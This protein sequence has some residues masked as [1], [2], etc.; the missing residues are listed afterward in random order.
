M[1]FKL[2][3]SSDPEGL[4][5]NQH[6]DQPKDEYHNHTGPLRRGCSQ[7]ITYPQPPWPS[8][9]VGFHPDPWLPPLLLSASCGSSPKTSSSNDLRPPSPG[10]LRESLRPR[11]RWYCSTASLNLPSARSLLKDCWKPG[12]I[13]R[14]LSLAASQSLFVSVGDI[15]PSNLRSCCWITELLLRCA[16]PSFPACKS[17]GN[18]FGSMGPWILFFCSFGCTAIF[19]LGA[20][21]L[22]PRPSSGVSISG[23]EPKSS[24][25]APSCC[26]E[27]CRSWGSRFFFGGELDRTSDF[28]RFFRFIS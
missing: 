26:F 10:T 18:S 25:L 12:G 9:F 23:L 3:F 19:C 16:S 24:R 21:L 7:R 28:S 2:I 20:R 6:L 1:T 13:G 8:F 5:S 15:S 4:P 17:A 27:P 11:L 22:F 14:I